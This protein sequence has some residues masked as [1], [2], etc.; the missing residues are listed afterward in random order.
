MCGLISVISKNANGL[1]KE[2]TNAFND[3]L[4]LDA[5]RGMDSTGVFMVDNQG[6]LE[7]AKE[8]SSGPIFRETKEYK[9]LL[10]RSFMRGSALVGHNRAATKGIVNDENAHPFV[11][12]DT[13]T[14]VHNGTLYNHKELA[15]TEVDSHAIAHTIHE[16]GGNVEAAL[17][18]ISGA[19]ALIWHNFKEDTLNFVRNSQRPLHWVETKDSWI[20]ASEA[21]MLSW[22]VQRY[23]FKPESEIHLLGEGTLVTYSLADR[24]WTVDN[25]K[26]ALT[27]YLP[28]VV[29]AP[30]WKREET[31]HE[32]TPLPERVKDTA[33]LILREDAI[34]S[35]MS[36]N[37]SARNFM[38]EMDGIS[39]HSYQTGVCIDYEK[40]SS[41]AYAIYAYHE[42]EPDIIIKCFLP[43]DTPE[44]TV[45]RM[46][47]DNEKAIFK[48]LNRQW[49]A[50]FNKAHGE[51]Y[52]M[53]ISNDYT[54]ITEMADD[55]IGAI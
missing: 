45:L 21:N 49:R 19:Y 29:Y 48:I 17:Q 35:S 54:I 22:I 13:I 46:A 2:Q 15:N 44:S 8:A 30:P 14:L 5:L 4:Y 32:V 38:R 51:G 25:K 34:A 47:C 39:A 28:P 52:G 23:N 33:K 40:Q 42:M 50:Y 7:L 24:K 53:L 20:W 1:T 12:D 41:G 10:G 27:R 6:N 31:V 11:V 43:N 26:I 18:K 3:L 37:T 9:D 55:Y 36:I 16:N